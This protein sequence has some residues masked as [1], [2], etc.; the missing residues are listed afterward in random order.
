MES[1]LRGSDD[2]RAA[3]PPSAKQGMLQISAGLPSP[4]PTRLERRTAGVERNVAWSGP[5]LNCGVIGG[6]KAAFLPLVVRMAARMS[7]RYSAVPRPPYVPVD[8]LSWNEEAWKL[9]A[10]SGH[11]IVTGYPRGPVNLPMWGRLSDTTSACPRH[12]DPAPAAQSAYCRARACRVAW[13]NATLGYYWFAHKIQQWW[14][15]FNA[16]KLGPGGWRPSCPHM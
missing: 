12:P 3:R 9:M 1:D 5:V 8:M 14:H 4:S 13:I 6:L 10:A 15:R 16:E 7:A 2:R 11:P